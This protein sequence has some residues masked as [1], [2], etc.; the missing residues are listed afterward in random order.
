MSAPAPG[1]RM[2]GSFGESK[3]ATPEVQAIADKVRPEVE[4]HIGALSEYVAEQ[5]RTQVVAGT[6][7]AIKVRVSAG[8]YIHIKVYKP[9]G[10]AEPTLSGVDKDKTAS[11]ALDKITPTH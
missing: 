8:H 3:P 10:D 4:S 9:L 7:Y 1:Q 6:N 2:P 11:D 5:F